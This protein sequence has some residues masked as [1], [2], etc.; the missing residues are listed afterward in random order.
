M[1][2]L[3]NFERFE[4]VKS[5]VR[6]SSWFLISILFF[7][8][9]FTLLSTGLQSYSINYC[10][11]FLS[12]FILFFNTLTLLA[13]SIIYKLK[14]ESFFYNLKKELLLFL[15]SF[16]SLMLLSGVIHLKY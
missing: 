7:A 10:I 16:A 11:A 13:L 3:Y 8:I 6:I 12:L 4:I 1:N 9:I 14:K 2:N 15:S 5:L